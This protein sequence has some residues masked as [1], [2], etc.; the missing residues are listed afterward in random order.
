[1][2]LLLDKTSQHDLEENATIMWESVKLRV[3]KYISENISENPKLNTSYGHQ[4][5]CPKGLE[6]HLPTDVKNI[7]VY[8]LIV[9]VI[10][11]VVFTGTILY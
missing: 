4:F 11:N 6:I 2:G 7:N 1:M 5:V 8:V 3:Q 10:V 9:I